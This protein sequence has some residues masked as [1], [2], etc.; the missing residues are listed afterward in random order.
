MIDTCRKTRI[1]GGERHI[2]MNKAAGMP[3]NPPSLWRDAQLKETLY[4]EAYEWTGELPEFAQNHS[5]KTKITPK[6][7][8]EG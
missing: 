4:T 1:P 8:S 5:P 2:Y 7:T 3:Y 6:P